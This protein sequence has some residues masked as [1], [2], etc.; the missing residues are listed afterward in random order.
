MPIRGVPSP[1]DAWAANYGSYG[2]STYSWTVEY[3]PQ[4]L[5]ALAN[6]YGGT[7]IGTYQGISYSTTLNGKTSVS[8]RA[9]TVTITGSK[10]S[11]TATKDNI[12]SLLDLKSTLITIS[13][14]SSGTSATYIK[15]SDGQ[16]IAFDDLSEVYAVSGS[17]GVMKA[18]GDETTLYVAGSSGVASVV[19]KTTANSSSGNIIISGK[20]YGHGVGLSQFGAIG[21]GD[22]G[23][24]WREI[25]EHYFCQ[26]NG[27]KLVELY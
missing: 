12:R 23:Y 18:N 25:I 26:G 3:T 24:S 14:G 11:V 22:D 17:G 1:H 27:I 2:A 6:S 21:M 19:N 20:G 13:D 15:G 7:D 16:A 9:M 8:G 4:E 5:V 10:G